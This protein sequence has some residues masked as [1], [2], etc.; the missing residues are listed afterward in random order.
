MVNRKEINR[1]FLGIVVISNHNPFFKVNKV[2]HM[3]HKASMHLK[4]SI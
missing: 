1:V 2:D 4:C 3:D